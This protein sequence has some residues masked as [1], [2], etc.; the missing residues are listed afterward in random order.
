MRRILLVLLLLSSGMAVVEGILPCDVTTVSPSCYVALRPGPTRDVLTIIDVSGAQVSES[1]GQLL[2]T[3]VSV[4]TTLTLGQLWRLADD[5]TSERA[6]RAAYFPE[7]VDE[8]VTRAQFAALMTESETAA[9]VAALRQLGYELT[10]DGARVEGLLEGGPSAGVLE[11]GDVVVEVDGQAVTTSDEFARL[12]GALAPGAVLM[13]TVDGPEGLQ[14]RSLTLGTNPDDASRGFAG[15]FVGTR[16]EVPLDV[17]I[18]A[19]SIGGPSAGMM[20]AL[21]IV[22]VL[23]PEDLTGGLVIAG[24]GEIRIDGSVGPIGGIHQKIAGATR[25]GD[26]PAAVVFLVPRGN[27]EEARGAS[28]PA[29]ITLVPIDTLGDA[30]AALEALRDGRTPAD[31]F[32]LEPLDG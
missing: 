3:T 19:G 12:V 1:A 30:V 27:I 4:Q 29:P 10:P 26:D 23:T 9:T 13:L 5:P 28:V 25:R 18:D 24:T 21:T 8:D 2:L 22:D 11:R 14:Q 7:D 16:V 17:V 6:P 20:F 31:S 32:V 15:L